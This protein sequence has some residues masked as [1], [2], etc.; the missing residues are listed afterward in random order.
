MKSGLVGGLIF[1]IIITLPAGAQPPASETVGPEALPELRAALRANPDAAAYA[2]LLGA[3]QKA[4][5]PIDLAMS[6]EEAVARHPGERDFVWTASEALL[7]LRA[8][9]P[10]LKYWR[11]LP[12]AAQKTPRGL[13]LRGAIHEADGQITEAWR[14]YQT[15]AHEEPKAH[16]ALARLAS[17]SLSLEGQRYFPPPGW[18]VQAGPPA[19]LLDTQSGMRAALTFM[20]KTKP[21]DAVKLTLSQALFVSLDHVAELI[22]AGKR[23]APRGAAGQPTFDP[24]RIESLPCAG[25]NSLMC[26]EAGPSEDIPAPFPTLHVGALDLRRA[27]TL[28]I[29]VED[30]DRQSASSVLRTLA[31][32]GR[33]TEE[34]KP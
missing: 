25:G 10:A 4:G 3:L 19:Q 23:K 34:S 22:A 18:S 27:G 17:H 16:E 30:A 13:W 14:A 1:S 32:A 24:I 11:M 9:E 7:D 12:K 21:L 8:P 2:A 26:V 28:V 29:V 15:A 6:A 31:D 5:P 33:I 20:S